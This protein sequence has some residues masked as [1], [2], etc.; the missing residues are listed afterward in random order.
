MSL[1]TFFPVVALAVLP[2][3]ASSAQAVPLPYKIDDA[4]THVNF[5][6]GH[7]GASMNRGRFD[8]ESGTVF[9]DATNKAGKVDVTVKTKSLTTGIA[10]FDKH[11]KSADFFNVAKYPTMRFV[12]D[13][14]V[15]NGDKLVEVPGQLTLMG[16]THPVTL[17]ANQFACYQNPMLKAEVCGGDF[18][19]VI[20][21]TQW[22]MDYLSGKGIPNEVTLRVSVE[23][24]RK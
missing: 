4:H 7:F 6:I 17:K 1:K 24:A 9:Y 10:A 8:A 15:F 2:M 11:L 23:A 20:D 19:A 5:E 13:Q 16:Q 14:M 3:L 12:S 18:E 21:R 22:G